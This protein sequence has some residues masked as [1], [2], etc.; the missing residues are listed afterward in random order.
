MYV[1]LEAIP[2]R[3][4]V[5]TAHQSIPIQRIVELQHHYKGK[6]FPVKYFAKPN[7]S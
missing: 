7:I 5:P 4:L 2:P 1:V 6:D 3:R